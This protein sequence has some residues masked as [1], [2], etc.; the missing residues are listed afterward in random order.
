MV[1]GQGG[2]LVYKRVEHGVGEF[3]AD[4]CVHVFTLVCM[5]E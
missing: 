3:K 4:L 1:T 2:G 5:C